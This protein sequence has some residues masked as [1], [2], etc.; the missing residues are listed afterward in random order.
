MPLFNSNNQKDNL[1]K[2]LKNS[3]V[4]F[5]FDEKGVKT[6]LLN[7]IQ[8]QQIEKAHERIQVLTRKSFFIR[9]KWSMSLAALL[10]LL[11]GTGSGIATADLSQPGDKLHSIDQWQEELML[12]LPLTE[13]QKANFRANIVDE[14]N[15]ELEYLL[16]VPNNHKQVK[17]QAVM[18]SSKSLDTAIEQVRTRI[19]ELE[20]KGKEA[21]A[22]KLK[23]VLNRLDTLADEQEHKVENLRK[24]SEDEETKKTLEEQLEFI[25]Q[26]RSK[27][28]FQNNRGSN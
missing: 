19:I 16:Q 4:D 18:D 21:Q 27:A 5:A 9:H 28:K 10:L 12:K 14:R 1:L 8:D 17:T 26:T 13:T 15:R 23:E 3:R 2:H 7:T 20:G 24:Q 6:R 25:K 11:A 22:E